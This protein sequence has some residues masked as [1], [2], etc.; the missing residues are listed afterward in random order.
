[1]PKGSIGLKVG[2]ALG[3]AVGDVMF[4][5]EKMCIAKWLRCKFQEPIF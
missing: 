5:P 2:R 1:M 3:T 4:D